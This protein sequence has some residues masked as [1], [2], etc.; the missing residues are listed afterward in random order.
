[1]AEDTTKDSFA[2]NFGTWVVNHKW[3]VLLLSLIVIFTAASGARF[4]SFI[5]DYRVFFSPDD[6]KLIAFEALQNTYTKN[7]NVL[8]VIAPKNGQVFTR[9][10]LDSIE[11]L[12]KEA[13]QTPYSIRVDSITN[14]QFITADG[15]DLIVRDLI[16]DSLSLSDK[17]LQLVKTIALNEPLLVNRAISPSAHVTGINVTIQLPEKKGGGLVPE[18]TEFSRN[19]AEKIKAQNPELDI[20]LTG[21][22]FMNNSFQESSQ[23]DMGTLVPLM[24]LIV[25]LVVGLLLRVISGTVAT[26]IVIFLSILAGMGLAGWSGIKLTPPSASAPNI[27]LTLAVAD[28]VHIL[29]SFLYNMRHGM[30]KKAAMIESIRINFQP[31]FLTSITT[32]IGFLSMNFSDS[33]PFQDLGNIVAMGVIAAFFLSV[34]TLPALMMALPVRVREGK[35]YGHNMMDKLGEFVIN[36]RG[37]LLWFLSAVVIVLV[38]FIPNNELN[39]E[40]VK[41]F[42]ETVDFRKATDFTT[43][44]LTGIY[45][46]EYSLKSGENGG[47][48][49]PEFLKTVDEFAQWYRKQPE[50]LHVNTVTDIFK[51]LNQNMHGDDFDWYRLPEDRNL[52]AQYLLL[53]EMSLPYGLDLNN[54]INIDKSA[55]R[56][57]ATLKSLSSNNL[58]AL[59]E[60]AQQWL[61]DNAPAE[62]KT[63]GVSPSI[64][65]AHIGKKNIMS[66]LTGT[67]I[68]LVLISFILVIALRSIK[69]GLISLIPNLVP[70]AMAFGVWGIFVGEVGLA[71]SVVSGMTLGIVVDDT[72]HFLS[73]YLRARREQ[74]KDAFDAVRYAFSTVGTALWVTS[75]ALIAGFLLLSFS[76]FKLNA[77]M[78]L[79]TAI[80]IAIALIIDFLLLPPLLMKLEG[81]KNEKLVGASAKTSS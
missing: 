75:L 73:K 9:K 24:F 76:A 19:L 38:S 57:T 28:C 74:N 61:K 47:V 1:M 34:T 11:L 41:Y 21:M 16:E 65:F 33:P 58:I 45:L 43:E 67:T 7:D 60:R 80:A 32:A 79:L 2:T 70:A 44:N 3:R 10:T 22:I 78:G 27:I 51:R 63:D 36:Q 72:V 6:P 5:T 12:T 55:V 52:A 35:T 64:M 53:Y 8:Y 48:S 14:F 37:K 18:I 23:K 26:V 62:M 42:D 69:I 17:D 13:W 59:E 4:L 81:K 71:L 29:V 39:D 54:Q 50:T 68:A 20:Y 30:E 40:F 66:M 25:I 46:I 31:I 56:F 77:A 15:D 49:N